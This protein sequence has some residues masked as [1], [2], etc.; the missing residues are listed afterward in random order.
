[1][2]KTLTTSLQVTLDANYVDTDDLNSSRGHLIWAIADALA[3]GIGADQASLMW[4]DTRTLVANF[5][6]LDLWGI[7]DCFGDTVYFGR[8]K[9][10]IV[11]NTSSTSD[12]W[13][14][15]AAAS[16]WA[17]WLGAANDRV[18][19]RPGGFLMLWAPDAAAYNIISGAQDV[20]RIDS[21]VATITYKIAVIGSTG[22]GTT[23]TSTCSST[24]SS[25]STTSSSSS[26]SSSTTTTPP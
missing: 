21:G 3:S 18:K 14:G 17:T 13:V 12:L 15:G 24:S 19:V 25:A 4:Y 20:L 1:M 8:V 26:S 9:G 22:A 16:T 5:E 11:Y 2:A 6:D 10:L 7:T 23:T